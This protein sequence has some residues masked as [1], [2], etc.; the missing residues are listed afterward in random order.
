VCYRSG[1]ILKKV[2]M[3]DGDWRYRSVD[4]DGIWRWRLEV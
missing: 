4:E 3:E 2:K 1:R